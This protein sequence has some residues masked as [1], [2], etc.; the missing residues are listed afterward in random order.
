MVATARLLFA[1]QLVGAA[2]IIRQ[3]LE[4]W[5]ENLAYNIRTFHQKGESRAE[6][7]QRV[8][9]IADSPQAAALRNLQGAEHGAP[10]NPWSGRRAGILFEELSELTHGRGRFVG[11]AQWDAAFL[12]RSSPEVDKQT[13]AAAHRLI[14][15]ATALVVRQLRVCVET[16]AE[17]EGRLDCAR[18]A[19]GLPET[20]PAGA[21]A[22]PHW[23]LWPL[24]PPTG[25]NELTRRRLAEYR[26][27]YDQAMSGSRPAGRLF[28]DDEMTD[29]FF[30]ATRCRSADT[31]MRAFEHEQ[32]D[33]GELNF[34]NLNGRE[35]LFIFAS[36]IAG[37]LALWEKGGPVGSAAAVAGS[38]LR[39][40]YW[41]WLEDDDRAMAM[42]R[43]VLE[44]VARVRTWR[45][46]PDKALAL[47][48]RGDATPRDWLD[49]SGLRRLGALNRALGEMSHFRASSDWFGARSLII[50]LQ[51]EHE[52]REF[53]EHTGRGEALNQVATLLFRE[54]TASIGFHSGSVEVALLSILGWFDRASPEA[55]KQFDEYLQHVWSRRKTSFKVAP[56]V[57]PAG[58]HQRIWKVFGKGTDAPLD[59]SVG[60]L[61]PF[62]GRQRY[63]DEEI[64]EDLK[65]TGP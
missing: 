55:E 40:A 31:A 22:P 13:V 61:L 38:A 7:I 46:K 28:R 6:F 33:L 18:L 60:R 12:L 5:T 49:E 19:R 43:V 42:L 4:R 1:G 65:P 9:E 34:D 15:A 41:L 37:L 47:E 64:P 52:R 25:L 21:N 16:F 17:E 32:E 35:H 62:V 26:D 23:S 30:V 8:W 45:N 39:S 63:G 2:M 57:G 14:T 56:F 29:L 36:E 24:V 48:E 58:D 59:P 3:Q 27:T 53:Y 54:C 50:D 10:I 51:P 11:A 44:Q 20:L